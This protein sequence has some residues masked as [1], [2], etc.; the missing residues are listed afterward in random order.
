MKK[1]HVIVMLICM[2]GS[3][4]IFFACASSKTAIKTALDDAA[5][6]CKANAP[7]SFIAILDPKDS[8]IA[9]IVCAT[10]EEIDAVVSPMLGER[11]ALA[12]GQ[13]CPTGS[14]VAT[15][16]DANGDVTKTTC[17]SRS[18]AETAAAAISDRRKA[19]AASSAKADPSTGY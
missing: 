18:E 1:A 5:S 15:I 6:A 11:K 19:A 7:Q 17:L 12:A 10:E 9:E 2:W 3:A 13:K 14:S 4:A 16:V 8:S